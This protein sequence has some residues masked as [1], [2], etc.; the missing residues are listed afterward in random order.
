MRNCMMNFDYHTKDHKH[1]LKHL[2]NC[3]LVFLIY[4]VQTILASPTATSGLLWRSPHCRPHNPCHR[5]LPTP[6][7]AWSG[8]QYNAIIEGNVVNN[9]SRAGLWNKTPFLSFHR[10]SCLH[11][12]GLVKCMPNFVFCQV[13]C[14]LRQMHQ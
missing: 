5:T 3:M 10:R 12:A 7:L 14:R 6:G 8:Q 9:I 4:Y 2:S 11:P 1:F 13:S